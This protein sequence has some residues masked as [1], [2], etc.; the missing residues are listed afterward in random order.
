MP[1]RITLVGLINNK[2]IKDYVKCFGNELCK[3]PFG[4]VNFSRK[5]ADTLPFHFTLSAWNI[6]LK[7]DVLGL[8]DRIC[9]NS[10]KISI[11][12]IKIMYGS[13]NSYVLYFS[14]AENNDLKKLLEEIYKILPTKKY[15]PNVFQFHI[16]IHIDKDLTK[17]EYMKNKLLRDFIPFDIQ[18]D[19]Y[20]LFE[21]YPAKEI[22]RY[23]NKEKV[24]W[25]Y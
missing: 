8:L 23:S 20:G 3:V 11:N 17:I 19:E 22:K 24:K 16:T 9:F 18:I 14:I 4:K 1:N 10:L 2:R 6:S 5:D 25:N 21:I 7:Q 12:D 13:E 15:N